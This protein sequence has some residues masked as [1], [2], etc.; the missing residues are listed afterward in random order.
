M[1]TRAGIDSRVVDAVTRSACRPTAA[2]NH[3]PAPARPPI[4]RVRATPV[5]WLPVVVVLG[6]LALAA[7]LIVVLAR[8]VALPAD[9]SGFAV[10]PAPLSR[11]Q[12][13]DADEGQI[14]EWGESSDM[15]YSH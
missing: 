13:L 4:E 8:L 5:P 2:P 14:Y 12:N 3:Q 1:N 10:G 6:A 9:G 11:S 7:V 15:R